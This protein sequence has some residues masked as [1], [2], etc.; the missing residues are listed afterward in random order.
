MKNELMRIQ[1]KMTSGELVDRKLREGRDILIHNLDCQL[2]RLPKKMERQFGWREEE[3]QSF[4]AFLNDAR[5]DF[6]CE[7]DLVQR[8]VRG[9]RRRTLNGC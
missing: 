2:R 6:V 4:E 7:T 1:L 9:A 5:E 8:D 3:T